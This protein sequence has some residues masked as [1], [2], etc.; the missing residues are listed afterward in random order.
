MEKVFESIVLLVCSIGTGF[1][2]V[3][4]KGRIVAGI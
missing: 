3:D 2:A 1:F 4:K